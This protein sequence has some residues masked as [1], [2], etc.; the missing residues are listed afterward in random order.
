MGKFDGFLICTDL[1]GTLYRNDKTI[2][3]ENREAIAYFKREGGYFTFITGRMPYYSMEAYRV[4]EPNVPFGCVNGGGVYDG[5]TGKY[6]WTCSMPEGVFDLIQCVDEQL[7]EIGIQVCTFEK[8]YFSKENETMANF[9]H[10][11]GVP[12]LICPYRDV[13]EPIAKIIFGSEAGEELLEVERLLRAH[14]LSATFDFVCSERTLFEILP[15]GVHKGL[16][17]AKLVEYLDIDCGR[18]IA[19]G[20]Y[21]NDIGM[22]GVAGLGVAVA[23]AVQAAKDAADVITVSNEEHAIARVIHDLERGVYGALP[24]AKER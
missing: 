24:V 10:L 4:V 11:T 12:N 22:F 13:K 21:N 8:T 18:T 9:R 14:P 1:D 23:N 15:K 2:S 7:P 16:A 17:L 3:Q 6:V 5:Q 19:I 20:D